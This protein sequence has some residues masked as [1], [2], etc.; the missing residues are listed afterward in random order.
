M[1]T[2]VFVCAPHVCLVPEK[3]RGGHWNPSGAGVVRD[4]ER[5]D[6]GIEN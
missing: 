6:V 4:C 2:C 1:S 5:P 3:A